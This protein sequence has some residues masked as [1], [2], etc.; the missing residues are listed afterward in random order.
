MSKKDKKDK[1]ADGGMSN[2]AT[3]MSPILKNSY[4][5]DKKDTKKNVLKDMANKFKDGGTKK[6]DMAC[7]KP[8]T[9]RSDSGKKKVVKACKDG[10]EKL[11]RYGADG[12]KHNYSKEAKKSFR[13]RH[14]CDSANDK[15]SAR[16]WACKDLWGKNKKIK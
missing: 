5:S 10:K 16:Y 14:K 15:L 4:S 2:T 1:Y 7:N 8:K 11:I 13:A 12:Y 9:D 6:D 3:S